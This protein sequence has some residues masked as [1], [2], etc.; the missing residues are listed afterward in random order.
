MV[1]KIPLHQ[2]T[3]YKSDAPVRIYVVRAVLGIVFQDKN[4][5]LIPDRAFAEVFH[6]Q[7][8]GKVIVSNMGKGAR[9]VFAKAFGMIV[10]HADAIEFRNCVPCQ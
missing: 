1:H 6:K 5:G 9:P 8:Y 4:D 7:P 10:A 3:G 2:P